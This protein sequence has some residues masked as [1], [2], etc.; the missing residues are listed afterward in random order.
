[1]IF[2]KIT[3]GKGKRQLFF[4]FIMITVMTLNIRET[5]YMQ[6]FFTTINITP[7]FKSELAKIY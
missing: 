3:N 7:L 1:M 2:I 4:L 6:L 5:N